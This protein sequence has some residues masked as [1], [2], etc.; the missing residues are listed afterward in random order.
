M[1]D[2]ELKKACLELLETAEAAI[3][4]T[5]DE[6]GRPH[7]RAMFNLRR[8]DQFPSLQEL[9]NDHSE[10]FLLYLGTNTSSRKVRQILRNPAVAVYYCDP[11]TFR[12][13]Q[14]SGTMEIISDTALK[15]RLWQDGWER[16]FPRG[17]EDPDYTVLKMLP[18]SAS[19]L[20]G[21]RPFGFAVGPDS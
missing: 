4:T 1:S 19:G 11:G 20:M 2:P 18:D 3:V 17:I 10:D 12:G 6:T 5:I 7:T 14:L 13:M 9:F 15:R 16:Y 8:K 21:G